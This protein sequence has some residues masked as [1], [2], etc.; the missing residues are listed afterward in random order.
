MS[1]ARRPRDRSGLATDRPHLLVVTADEGLKDF[2][3]E[4]LTLAGFWVSTVGSAVQ[5]LEVFRLRSFDLVLVDAALGG[6]GAVELVLRLRGR[7][8]RASSDQ[9]RTDVPLLFVAADP[10][11]LAPDEAVAAGADGILVAPL[12]L[13][14]VATRLDQEVRAWRAAHPDRPYADEAAQARPESS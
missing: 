9:P 7:S 12:E 13:D 14:E 5:T 6:I 4:G 11:E 10:A 1:D 3:S 8:D 2:L